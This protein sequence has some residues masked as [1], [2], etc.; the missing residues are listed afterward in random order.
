MTIDQI[1]LQLI[2]DEII[3]SHDD[4]Q[5]FLNKKGHSINQSTLSR[6]LKKLNI[7]KTNGRYA[8]PEEEKEPHIRLQFAA[9]NIWIVRTRPGYAQPVAVKVDGSDHPGVAGT[10]SGDD[11]IFIALADPKWME[12][13]GEWLSELTRE[14]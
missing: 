2:D 11:T 4:F 13:V 3:T 10:I 6:H 5:T 8:L 14:M 9:P 1:L 12:E 7:S